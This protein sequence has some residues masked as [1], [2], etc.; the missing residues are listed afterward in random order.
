MCTWYV[1]SVAKSRIKWHVLF[2]K[3]LSG[4]VSVEFLSAF[5]FSVAYFNFFQVHQSPKGANDSSLL[6]ETQFEDFGIEA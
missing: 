4:E 6:Y 3:A 2:Y 5:C 1:S